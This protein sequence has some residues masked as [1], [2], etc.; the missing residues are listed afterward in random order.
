MLEFGLQILG[1]LKNENIDIVEEGS[2]YFVDST[3]FS[4]LMGCIILV[5]SIIAGVEV[6]NGYNSTLKGSLYIITSMNC[7][8]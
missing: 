5:N 1:L 7:S 3:W 2:S 8:H 6:D 4:I